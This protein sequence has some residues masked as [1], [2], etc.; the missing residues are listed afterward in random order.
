MGTGAI[1]A[2]SLSAILLGM[3]FYNWFKRSDKASGGKK[4]GGGG[5]TP[6]DDDNTQI[7]K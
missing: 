7:L 2:L 1:I 5:G 4:S 3:F 6:K